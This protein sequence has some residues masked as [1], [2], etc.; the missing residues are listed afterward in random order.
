MAL[1]VTEGSGSG[2]VGA[3]WGG[4]EIVIVGVPGAVGIAASG[5]IATEPA[6]AGTGADGAP[7]PA[8]PNTHKPIV[9]P[10]AMASNSKSR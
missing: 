2:S 7:L 6:G 3:A 4:A 5:V 8:R 1:S 9:T 10:D